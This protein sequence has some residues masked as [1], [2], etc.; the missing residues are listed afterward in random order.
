MT[1]IGSKDVQPFE[2]AHIE[3]VRKNAGEC[4]VLLKKD[5]HF[6]LKAPGKIAAYGNG[7][8]KTIK[9]GTGSGDVNVRHFVTVEEGLENAGF[10]LTTKAWLDRYDTLFAASK[11][12]FFSNI[13]EEAKKAG[14]DPMWYSMGKSMVEFEHTIP[15]ETSED[16]DTAIYVLARNSGEGADRNPVKGDINLTDTEIRIIKELNEKYENFMLVLNIGGLVDVSPVKDV[17]N[18]LN[19]GQLGTP[20][21]DVLADLLLGKSYPS[22]KLTMTWAAISDYPSTDGFADYNDTNY[23]EGIYVGYRYFDTFGKDVLYPFGYGL[24]FTE[25]DVKAEDVSINGGKVTVKASVKN[26]GDFAGK[27]VVQLYYSAPDGKLDKPYQEL[28]CYK[29]TPELKAG[30]SCTVELSFDASE[31]AS[32]DEETHSYI[33]EK[34]KYYLRAGTHCRS[35]HVAGA[36]EV[37]ETLTTSLLKNICADGDKVRPTV[38]PAKRCPI[39]YEGEKAEKEA[40]KTVVLDAAYVKCFKAEYAEVPSSE[41]TSET[42]LWDDVTGGRKTIRDFASSLSD[43]DL[44]KI[45]IGAFNPEAKG[46]SV[47]GQ[48]SDDV[49]GAAGQTTNL[50]KK[51]N[52]KPLVM[53][54]GPAGVRISPS[55]KVIGGIAKPSCSSFNP[56]MMEMMDDAA[57][58]AFGGVQLS[59]EEKEAQEYYQYCI[60]IPIGSSL[61]QSFNPEYEKSLGDIVGEEME[62]FGVHLWLAPAMNI[63]RSPLCGRNFEYFS[64]DPVVSGHTA[65]AITLGVQAHK[66]CGTTIKHYC[67]NNQETNRMCN[68]SIVGERALREIYLKG[69]ELCVKE[70]QPYT[71]MSSYNLV[72]G[73]HSDTTKDLIDRVLR[74]EWDFHGFV[75][76]DWLVTFSMMNAPGGKHQVANAAGLVKAGNDVSMPGLLSDHEEIMKALSDPNHPYAITR[77]DVQACAERVLKVI[78]ELA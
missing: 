42:V 73:E 64:E 29:K 50:L 12:A 48:A 11:K 3:A 14:V 4:T 56:D 62:L 47:I 61:S 22:G 5:G 16:T 18:I 39:S 32:Y 54:D 17:K 66:G 27:E 77:A 53:A 49:A 78:K 25:F 69:F 63:Y 59:E 10:T 70:S 8:R 71:I 76:T 1:R 21:G 46:M 60:A 38:D 74:D 51:Y 7:V 43:E 6:P 9:G 41:K 19:L 26:T 13:R 33:L 45:C 65:A 20:T 30:Q 58:A 23:G 37:S 36:V 68:N 31:M 40:A 75:M 28:V 35:T 72:N 15:L 34:G 57:K 67:C 52:L 24:S 55:Y 2:T 44:A